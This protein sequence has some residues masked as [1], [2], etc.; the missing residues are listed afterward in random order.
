MQKIIFVFFLVFSTSIFCGA[1]KNSFKKK[2]PSKGLIC[3]PLAKWKKNIGKELDRFLMLMTKEVKYEPA[4]MSRP[5]FIYP[6][7]RAQYSY[8]KGC[9][10]G[11]KKIG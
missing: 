7:L 9:K 8:E 4:M 11:E 10:S 3:L 6:L 5:S 2:A 1:K